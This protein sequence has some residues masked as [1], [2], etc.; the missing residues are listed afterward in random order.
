M[1]VQGPNERDASWRAHRGSHHVI[2]PSVRAACAISDSHSL[3]PKM[4]LTDP[5]SS[6]DNLWQEEWDVSQ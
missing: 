4:S 2:D 3:R 5:A 6:R 1:R